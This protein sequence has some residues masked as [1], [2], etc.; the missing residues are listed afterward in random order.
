MPSATKE[1][2]VRLGEI[3]V[4]ERELT[5]QQLQKALQVQGLL[6][7]RLGTTLLE[8]GLVDE[9]V[10]LDALGRQRSTR[11]VSPADLTGVPADVV[12]MVPAR[13]AER[14]SVVPFEL[15][16]RTLS[17]ASMD[18]G[19]L[20]KEDEIGFLTS[21]M[22]RTCIALEHRVFEALERYYRIRSPERHQSLSRLLA[23]KAAGGTPR[24]RPAPPISAPATPAAPVLRDPPRSPPCD[25]R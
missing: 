10:V 4:R 23:R 9:R 16:G 5:R 6:G 18:S 20:L 12:R 15:K 2:A 19:D 13:L 14:Y 24:T 21:C 17:V 25:A 8:E 11:T 3:L 7:G 22:V 1:R